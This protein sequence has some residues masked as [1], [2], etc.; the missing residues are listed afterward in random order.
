M[1]KQFADQTLRHPVPKS[2][3]STALCT[4][5]ALSVAGATFA[6]AVQAEPP[7]VV[8]DIPPVH[9]L[10][11]Q[12]MGDLGTPVLLLDRG[13]DAHSFQ[14]RPSQAAALSDAALVFWI[15]PEMTPW[16]DRALK[17]LGGG[18]EA[19]ALLGAGGSTTREFGESHGDHDD[20]GDDDH[21]DDDH[22]DHDHA[23]EA[24]AEEHDH[25]HDSDH[26]GEATDD[27]GHD[28]DDHAHETAENVD[29]H[30][31]DAEGHAHGG[32]DPHAW[33]DPANAKAWLGV[34]RDHL[35]EADPENEAA[36]AANAE[37]ALVRLDALDADLRDRLA[38]A[39]DKPFVVF[40][41]AYGYFAAAYD[42]TIAGTIA[43]GDAADPGAGRISAIREELENDGAVCIFAEANHSPDLVAMLAEGSDVRTGVLDPAGSLLDPGA[44]LYEALLA[45]MATEI[46]GC[47]TS[48][49]G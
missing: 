30:D 5:L 46:A 14:L 23:A 1:P 27:H 13:A 41:D 16:L 2:L 18:A 35:A 7:V 19:V 6:T 43:L 44:D 49:G 39:A 15:G 4:S 40:H 32:V 24:A 20:H 37:A 3:R 47:L 9:S 45:G 17:G 38:P 33:L 25:D 36:Y 29:D 21:G 28:H 31:H 26:A 22:D 48:S 8:T 11:A 10:V 12:V 42:L 34:I